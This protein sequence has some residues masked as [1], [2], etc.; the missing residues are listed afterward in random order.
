MWMGAMYTWTG[1]WQMHKGP[2]RI[3]SWKHYVLEHYV[4]EHY[5]M[6]H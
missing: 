6:E 2:G 1:L 5:V 3:M 4:M